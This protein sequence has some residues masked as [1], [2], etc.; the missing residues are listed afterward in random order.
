MKTEKFIVTWRRNRQKGKK[1]YIAKFSLLYWLL[2]FI[3]I[4]RDFSLSD[5]L[6]PFAAFIGLF[7][8]LNKNW[9]INE[10]KY[11]LLTEADKE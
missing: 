2:A 1:H 6:I 10:E 9:E 3:F 8:G 7:F 5:M 11:T 4:V